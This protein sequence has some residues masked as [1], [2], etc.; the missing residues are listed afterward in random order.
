MEAAI[1]W[2]AR[3]AIVAG[4]SYVAEASVKFVDGSQTGQAA[5]LTWYNDADGGMPT[6]TYGFHGWG[7]GP[8][9][10]RRVVFSI[11]AG[12]DDGSYVTAGTVVNSR[13]YLR[14]VVQLNGNG[15]HLY[16][17]Y[18]KTRTL[19]RGRTRPTTPPI[20][21]MRASAC[22]TKRPACAPTCASTTSTSC[23]R[24]RP[25]RR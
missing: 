18:Y 12:T 8:D 15:S 24:A 10:D 23:R 13:M 6:A 7:Q 9:I 22:S 14:V 25:S 11:L 2:T 20:G 1:A 17:M 19:R 16:Q 3:P 5:G 21:R 4:E